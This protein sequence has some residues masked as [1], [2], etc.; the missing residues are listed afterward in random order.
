MVGI[1]DT[2]SQLT[3]FLMILFD[4]MI[5]IGIIPFL[6]SFAKRTRDLEKEM[7]LVLNVIRGIKHENK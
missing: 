4:I 6:F 3:Q 1:S 5:V 2:L 7:Y